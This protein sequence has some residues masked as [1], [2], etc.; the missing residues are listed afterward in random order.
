MYE[1][2]EKEKKKLEEEILDLQNQTLS[3]Q[4]KYDQIKKILEGQSLE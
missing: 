3:Y 4:L 1:E 2:I